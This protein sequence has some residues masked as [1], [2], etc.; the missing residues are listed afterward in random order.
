VH[1]P[2]WLLGLRRL[3]PLG[4]ISILL[5]WLKGMPLSSAWDL[6]VSGLAVLT[7]A[8][9]AWHLAVAARALLHL[10]RSDSPT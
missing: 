6:V 9:L 3:R 2:A 1:I 7:L 4:G 10:D 5:S 8:A